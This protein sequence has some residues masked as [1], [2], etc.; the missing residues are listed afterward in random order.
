MIDNE[1]L[2]KQLEIPTTATVCGV[3]YNKFLMF[4]EVGNNRQVFGNGLNEADA[5]HA[6]ACTIDAVAKEFK[7]S[8]VAL[9]ALAVILT[10][11]AEHVAEQAIS[12]CPEDL[13]KEIEQEVMKSVGAKN[14]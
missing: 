6:L 5:I 2:K 4:G 7:D 12:I 13:K 14:V 9:S 10:E 11:I 3:E 1:K 8:P